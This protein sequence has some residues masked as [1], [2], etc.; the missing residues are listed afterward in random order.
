MG[1]ASKLHRASVLE[2]SSIRIEQRATQ[3]GVQAAQ[4]AC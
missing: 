2:Q 1:Q 4:Q 3:S